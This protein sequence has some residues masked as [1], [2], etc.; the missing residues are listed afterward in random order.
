M[1][2]KLHRLVL[3]G[4]RELI[5]SGVTEVDSSEDRRI[6]LK[7][8]LG[9]MQV[10]GEELRILNL[11]LANGDAEIGG[12]IDSLVYMEVALKDKNKKAFHRRGNRLFK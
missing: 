3:N 1:E 7:T 2:E 8:V 11:D 10:E 12:K 6:S 5:L 4:R 9:N